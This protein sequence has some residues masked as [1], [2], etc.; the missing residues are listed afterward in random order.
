M[1][2]RTL[3]E[4]LI[5]EPAFL[6]GGWKGYEH[7]QD[8]TIM[9]FNRLT[10]PSKNCSI[11]IFDKVLP[12]KGKTLYG[13]I[14]DENVGIIGNKEKFTNA[15]GLEMEVRVFKS[16][17]T[18]LKDVIQIGYANNRMVFTVVAGALVVGEVISGQ[19][20]GATAVIDQ[21]VGTVLFL[22]NVVGTFTVGETILGQTSGATATTVLVPETLFHQITE[23]VN[24]IPYGVHEYYFDSWF[25]TKLL[26]SIPNSE[27]SKNLSRLIWVNGYKDPNLTAPL[28]PAA[29]PPYPDTRK[30]AVYS[31]TGGVA[32]IT[33][34]IA[35]T[36]IS[37]NPL[38]TWRSL[39]F[40][41]DA[42]GAVNVVINGVVHNVPV[43]GDIDTSTINVAS[44]AGIAIGDTVTSKIE[45]D[46]SPIPFDVCRKNKAYMF[47]GNWA[48]QQLYQSN[49]FNRDSG[50]F[51][52][53][54]SGGLLN[55]LTIPPSTDYTGTGSHV[56]HVAIDSVTPDV[57]TQTFTPG[58]AG[59]VN[60][61]SFVTTG[62]SGTGTNVYKISIVGDAGL[63]FAGVPVPIPTP[64]EVL[65]GNISGAQ[66]TVITL[67][68]SGQD[69]FLRMNPGSVPFQVGETVTGTISG[70]IPQVIFSFRYGDIFQY[71]LNNTVGQPGLPYLP[72]VG[73]YFFQIFQTPATPFALDDGITFS[74]ENYVGH[75]IGSYWELTI[76]T[77]VP[78]TF[79]WWID[80]AA[81]SA[82]LV[83]IT[84]SVQTL[85]NGVDILFGS[86]TGHSFGDLWDIQVDQE[87]TRAW[88]NF[89][90]TLPV[91]K[92]YEGYIYQLPSN[93]WTMD[94]QE[95]SM[96]VNTKYGEW[97][98]ISTL[99]SSDLQSETVSLTPLKQAGSLKVIH[100]YMTGH[101]NDDLVYVSIDKRLNT[102]GRKQFLEKPQT[103][104]LSELVD[105]DFQACSFIGGR[106]KYLNKNLYVSSPEDAMMHCYE[107]HHQYWQPPKTFSETGIL[108]I[109]GNDLACHSNVRNQTFTMFTNSAGD[110]GTAYA[111]DIRTPYT[112]V[113][114]RWNSK[115]SSMSFIEGYLT[116]NPK[117][118]HTVYL[119]VNGCGGIYQHGVSA[120]QCFAPDNSPFGEGSFGSHSFGSDLDVS[121]SYFNEIFK[122]YAPVL[123]YYFLSIGISC[124]AKSH[125]WS[126][127]TLGMNGMFSETGNNSLVNPNTLTVNNP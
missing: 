101:I 80:S 83:P 39:G 92:P 6:A 89:Y 38:T 49:G 85:A 112:A 97:S 14:F 28:P 118:L 18:N 66:A 65:T 91:R 81:P 11:P 13:Q 116:G 98:L 24:P 78:D 23:N 10:Y 88:I 37:I 123:Q 109:I 87:V 15:G 45:I 111:V 120:I 108:T 95:E 68:S 84:T 60:D 22:T 4:K 50:V 31:W 51:V 73:F 69:P 27:P 63:T 127:L 76:Q 72:A 8:E 35:N 32:T 3:P 54:F 20:S 33:S 93:F 29:N 105:K 126:I 99:I 48:A 86:D 16:L 102:I 26:S 103:G 40:T 67:D 107:T 122:A 34:F 62:Y 114:N 9:E 71:F 12:D 25:D 121:S 74:F 17:D 55:D 117:L 115:F 30:G 61:G 79:K 44:T 42:S 59:G 36:S 46:I 113:G 104:Y 21:I 94:T 41:E 58:A 75:A 110:N 90:Y 96:Y 19:T 2:N 124:V 43:P 64:G 57:N 82:T 7:F 1:A 119:G 52:L 100:P 56:Y 5:D 47:Y 70:V 53:S 106:I 77:Q 125:T